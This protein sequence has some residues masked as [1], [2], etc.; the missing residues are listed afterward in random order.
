MTLGNTMLFVAAALAQ[1]TLGTG[2]LPGPPSPLAGDLFLNEALADNVTTLADGFGEFD[3]YLEIYNAGAG[4]V[5]LNGWGLTDDALDPYKWTLTSAAV[6]PPGGHLL[7]WLDGDSLQG[8]LHG[9]FALSS[10]GETLILTDELGFVVDV[11]TFTDQAP[12]V[13]WGRRT[14]GAPTLGFLVPTPESPN[15]DN[16]PP[17]V[18]DT[19]ATPAFPSPGQTIEVL[20][21]VQ[22]DDGDPLTVTL[23][24]ADGPSFTAIPMVLDGLL[25]SAAI[26]EHGYGETVSYYVE[27]EDDQGG[28]TLRPPD[29]PDSTR[30]QQVFVGIA[31]VRLNEFMADNA[32]TI[33]DEEG[34]YE[35][36]IEIVNLADFDVDLSGLYLTDD[37]TEPKMWRFPEG[38]TIGPSDQLLIWADNDDGDP[39]LHTNFKLSAAGEY[40]GLY[41]PG[42]LANGLLDGHTFGPQS[43]DISE[44][45]DVDGGGSFIAQPLPTPD[46]HNGTGGWIAVGTPDLSPVNVTPGAGFGFYGAILNRYPTGQSTQAWTAAVPPVGGEISPVMGPLPLTLS[47]LGVVGAGLV[48]VVPPTAPLGSYTYEVRAGA[49]PVAESANGFTVSVE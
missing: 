14:D 23:Y 28:R 38:T 20:A 15:P 12:D 16:A 34:K 42:Y 32:T 43:P 31:P 2:T 11:M 25:Y 17:I 1:L 22:E 30:D 35:D 39:G 24:V 4:A 19:D 26:P 3:D 37:A 5:S 7:L 40:V 44:G 48:Q 27:A 18:W 10:G 8:P 45:R 41:A 33:Q 9:P 47:A 13:S 46:A 29:A 21:E 36:W 6:V 49:F